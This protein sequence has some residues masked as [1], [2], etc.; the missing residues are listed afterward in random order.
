[1]NALWITIPV[2]LA[3][4]AFFVV[5]FLAAVKR[6]QFDDLVTPAHRILDE[7]DTSQSPGLK[8]KE[9]SDVGSNDA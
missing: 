2:T 5:A 9:K 6:G 3:L 7:V 4:A 8:G 1:M